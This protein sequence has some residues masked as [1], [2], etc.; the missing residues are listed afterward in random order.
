MT[1]EQLTRYIR[2]LSSCFS[3]IKLKVDVDSI[4]NE[5]RAKDTSEEEQNKEIKTRFKQEVR[6]QVIDAYNKDNEG[7]FKK[8]GEVLND[9]DIDVYLKTTILNMSIGVINR[10]K[11]LDY[12]ACKSIIK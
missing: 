1:N 2:T 8:M 5:E 11:E 6:K 4:I 7:F 12:A 10:Q 9:E 3:F